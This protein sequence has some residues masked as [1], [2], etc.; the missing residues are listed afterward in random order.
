MPGLLLKT[1]NFQIS[2]V[3]SAFMEL[4]RRLQTACA[5]ETSLEKVEIFFR[6]EKIKKILPQKLIVKSAFDRKC[7][8]EKRKDSILRTNCICGPSL[9]HLEHGTFGE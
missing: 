3:F 6:T 8:T 5:M 2:I 7:V 1:N 9:Y 4:H